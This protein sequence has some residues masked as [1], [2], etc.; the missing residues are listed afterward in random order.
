MRLFSLL[1][2]LESILVEQEGLTTSESL[3]QE[4]TGI[5]D[6]IR[7]MRMILVA[8]CCRHEIVSRDKVMDEV[9]LVDDDG[10]DCPEDDVARSAISE[11]DALM[12]TFG[13]EIPEALQ[14]L[15]ESHEDPERG[16]II[17]FWGTY[18]VRLMQITYLSLRIFE[19]LSAAGSLS[20]EECTSWK[21]WAKNWI[22]EGFISGLHIPLQAQ[23]GVQRDLRTK[24]VSMNPELE[25][26]PEDEEFSLLQLVSVWVDCTRHAGILSSAFGEAP[27]L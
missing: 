4:Q 21:T 26:K 6:R 8:L 27:D 9:V 19:R 10:E 25:F 11:L 13:F 24:V 17:Q 5:I 23:L 15:A 22:Q 14:R 2:K 20:T 16:S 1:S 18:A 12:V 7:T 3:V